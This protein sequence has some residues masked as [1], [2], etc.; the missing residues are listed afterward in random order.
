VR[1]AG[2]V[3]EYTVSAVEFQFRKAGTEDFGSSPKQP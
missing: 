3:T 2:S 1:E